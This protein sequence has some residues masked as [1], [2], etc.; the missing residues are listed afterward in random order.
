MFTWQGAGPLPSPRRG[1]AT[2][3]Q[4]RSRPREPGRPLPKP[5]PPP[6]RLPRPQQSGES[7]RIY[8]GLPGGTPQPGAGGADP[9]DPLGAACSHPPPVHPRPQRAGTVL[10][11]PSGQ[12]RCPSPVRPRPPTP[13]Q[14]PDDA[15][16]GPFPSAPRGQ[17]RPLLSA[18]P[19][20]VGRPLSSPSPGLGVRGARR[21]LRSGRA[22]TSVCPQPRR[23]R[24]PA[25]PPRQAPQPLTPA[26]PP[27]ARAAVTCGSP[28]PGPSASAGGGRGRSTAAD[29][30][31]RG[32]GGG[33][34]RR[35]QLGRLGPAA[36]RA[37]GPRP[38]DARSG[39]RARAR[40][41]APRSGAPQ[42]GL[43]RRRPRPPRRGR[44]PLGSGFF[45]SI[46]PTHRK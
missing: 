38:L 25:W 1:R 7:C 19:G 16:P 14:R 26:P 11:A 3:P 36:G 27:Q 23:P 32:G 5:G 44:K 30:A 41:L 35:L 33:S 13:L 17:G 24:H 29:G 15:R 40:S 4:L 18:L 42:G 20:R 9:A 31:A 45:L 34:L 8:P 39:P 12:D 43:P 28:P 2:A 21:T 37:G 22:R 10:P 6:A 46:L